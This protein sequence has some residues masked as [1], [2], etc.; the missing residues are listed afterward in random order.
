[1][2]ASSKWRLV[3][4]IVVTAALCWPAAA[5]AGP[6]VAA[7]TCVPTMFVGVHG[8]GEE[9]G[10]VGDELANLYNAVAPHTGLPE[11]GLGGWTDYNFK[12]ALLNGVDPVVILVNLQAAISAGATDLA[13]Q[14]GQQ[15]AQC[16]GEHFVIAGF[17]QGAGVVATY[18]EQHTDLASRISEITLWAD[19]AFNGADQLA[20]G[21]DI[22]SGQ[23]VNTADWHGLLGTRA[24]FPSAWFGKLHS[25][26]TTLD[27]VCNI[28]NPFN[29]VNIAAHHGDERYEP[30]LDSSV[31]AIYADVPT[32][33]D[34][35]G[36]PQFYTKWTQYNGVAGMLGQPT[37]DPPAGPA[38]AAVQTFA[39]Q[40]C[41]SGSA[42][43]WSSSSGTHEMHGCI[44]NSFV[45]TFGGPG[46]TYGFPTTDEEATDGATGRVNHMTGTACGSGHGS[47][48][49]FGAATGTWPVHG[50]IYQRYEQI[51][52]DS[53]G[54][55]LPTTDEYSV[56]GGVE[57]NFSNG[58]IRDIG[59]AITVTIGHSSPAL[60]NTDPYATGCAGSAHPESTV[61][62]TTDGL[63]ALHLQWSAYCG[64]NW[65]R[66][67]PN[68]G[69]GGSA[70]RVEIWVERQESNGSITKGNV[71]EFSPNG[72]VPAW[73]DQLYAPV[74]HARACDDFWTISTKQWSA[75]VCTT[76]V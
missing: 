42:I 28:A 27:P 62:S 34:V 6:A 38:T 71:F 73:S 47:G 57:Q 26:C 10:V 16:P 66:I 56:S 33:F 45:H 35:S 75:P 52:E 36:G 20:E 51:G 17:S 14:L 3:Q 43:V 46:G 9:T 18:A 58:N 54:L 68:T 15:A 21:A 4:G 5:A 13:N 76:W 8:T 70:L 30:V 64:T 60:D 25:Y 11:E 39:G 22:G 72:T 50:C 67:V 41:G 12:T 74:L 69:N 55:G 65:T 24:P 63:M 48:L 40:D 37:D 31:G 7:T 1:M 53:S 23:W 44:Y 32:V 2:G 59:G 49:F 19:P 29:I 61:A